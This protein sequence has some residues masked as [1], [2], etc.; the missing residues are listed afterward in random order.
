MDPVKNSP[1]YTIAAIVASVGSLASEAWS[2]FH[3]A[4][5]IGQL[6]GEQGL[7]P[8]EFAVFI[9]ESEIWIYVAAALALISIP[10]FS[11]A[12]NERSMLS[13]WSRI[14]MVIVLIVWPL[15]ALLYFLVLPYPMTATAYMISF[16][17]VFLRLLRTRHP[18]DRTN[19]AV[20]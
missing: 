16:T 19:R 9:R 10:L 7:A 4:Q 6:T 14:M 13:L 18:K 15:F 11:C 8:H 12:A 3:V 1:I 2:K 20:S 5:G 17:A